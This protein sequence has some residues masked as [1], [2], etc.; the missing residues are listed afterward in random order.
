M[1]TTRASLLIRIK[2]P[3]NAKA[4]SEF[5]A[6]YRPILHRYATSRGLSEDDA[7]D[8]VQFGMAAVYKH[9]KNFDYDPD[10]GSFR[11]W[12]RTV[13]NNHIRILQKKR[14]EL[15][16]KSQQLRMLETHDE[17]PEAAFDRVWLEE[18][19]KCCL[20]RVQAEVDDKAFK[21]F[22]SYVID[23]WPV[24]RVCDTMGMN[25]NQLYKIKWRITHKLQEKMRE[26]LEGKGLSS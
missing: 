3:D 24:R 5:T 26:L 15:N 18:H 22:K 6:I 11:G 4:W 12:L 21:A 25:R 8:V 1:D 2:D 23:E 10:K 7:E 14:R 9:I 17:S 13:V 20:Q 19:L 16:A